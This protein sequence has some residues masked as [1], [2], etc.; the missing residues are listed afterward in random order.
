MSEFRLALLTSQALFGELPAA[1]QDPFAKIAQSFEVEANLHPG[2][3]MAGWGLKE[4]RVVIQLTTTRAVVRVENPADDEEA[5]AKS[6]SA[7]EKLQE[8]LQLGALAAF[9]I[10]VLLIAD[11]SDRQLKDLVDKWRSTQPRSRAADEA[12]NWANVIVLPHAA[13][14]RRLF[15]GPALASHTKQSFQLDVEEQVFYQADIDH[16]VGTN[17]QFVGTV[18][19]HE[20]SASIRES[21]DYAAGVLQTIEPE[22]AEGATE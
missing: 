11:R 18:K 7:W 2:E 13:G 6:L 22:P 20:F 15:F 21:R 10:R 1:L 12:I 8:R 3:M 16:V 14:R 9:S 5:I 19:R 4:E 17:V